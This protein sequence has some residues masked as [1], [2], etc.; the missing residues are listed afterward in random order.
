MAK[1]GLRLAPCHPDKADADLHRLDTSIAATQS[2]ST[3][4][5]AKATSP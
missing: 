4:V 5:D 1:D 2:W 3:A